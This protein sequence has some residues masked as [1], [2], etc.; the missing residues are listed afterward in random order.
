MITAEP[1]D[2]EL[3][4]PDSEDQPELQCSSSEEEVE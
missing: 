1:H 3:N 4:Q 2:P